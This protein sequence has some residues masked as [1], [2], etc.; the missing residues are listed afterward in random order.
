MI[1]PRPDG[2]QRGPW[3]FR[4]RAEPVGIAGRVM[5]PQVLGGVIRLARLSSGASLRGMAQL[6]EVTPPV[7]NHV[8][9]GKMAVTAFQLE[10]LAYV[11]TRLE[12]E[13]FGE[14]GVRWQGWEL[15]RIATEIA[16]ALEVAGYW[17]QWKSPRRVGVLG[18]FVGYGELI[19]VLREFCPGDFSGRFR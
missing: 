9:T 15:L 19:G 7:L 12:A 6:L 13:R 18:E 11:L 3:E 4:D 14:A 1:R 2:Q 16:D 8:E 5:M 17:V 10:V